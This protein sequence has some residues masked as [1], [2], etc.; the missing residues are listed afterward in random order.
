[1]ADKFQLVL[2]THNQKKRRELS[3]LLAGLPIEVMTLDDIG[4]ALEVEET[5]S[6]FAENAALKATV[7]AQHLNAWVMGEDS[8]LSVDALQGQPGVYSS[9]FAGAEATDQDNNAK[10]VDMLASV[11]LDRRTA[12]YTCHMSLS[13]PS[14]IVVID[15]EETCRGRIVLEPRGDAGFGYDPYFELQEY[16]LTFAELG[17][18]VKSVLSH[19]ARAMRS[20]LREFSQLP[21]LRQTFSDTS[22]ATAT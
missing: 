5:G 3:L 13:D 10:L 21:Q 18:T 12:H 1:M 9:R 20:F 8:G 7:Q 6:T 4:N 17:D 19:R 2:G 15:V 22:H 16:H 14:G 11:P